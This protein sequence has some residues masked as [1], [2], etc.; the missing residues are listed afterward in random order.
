MLEVN[1]SYC[2]FYFSQVECNE[3]VYYLLVIDCV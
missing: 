2:V 3:V 1:L